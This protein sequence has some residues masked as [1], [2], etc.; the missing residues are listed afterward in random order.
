MNLLQSIWNGWR[1]FLN[2]RR[3]Y[4]R[5]DDNPIIGWFRERGF[6]H[7]DEKVMVRCC[8]S[9]VDIPVPVLSY[10]IWQSA[11][12]IS[13]LAG[14]GAFPFHWKPLRDSF[15][16]RLSRRSRWVLYITAFLA[17]AYFYWLIAFLPHREGFLFLFSMS[18]G[19][20]I[21]M[22]IGAAFH[23]R[24]A[25]SILIHGQ[26]LFQIFFMAVMMLMIFGIYMLPFS[27]FTPSKAP[28]LIMILRPVLILLFSFLLSGS[29]VLL[30]YDRAWKYLWDGRIEEVGT[31]PRA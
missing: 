30:D 26:R 25:A 9:A 27:F 20:S 8:K 2:C 12:Y 6:N 7:R 29:W 19:A 11:N 21:G 15:G 1:I 17:L 23:T 10:D 4:Y 24:F 16:K 22:F 3:A 14:R 18:M 28:M 13:Y 5:A 31:E